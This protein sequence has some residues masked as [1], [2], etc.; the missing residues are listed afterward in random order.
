MR[1][2]ACRLR[3]LRSSRMAAVDG[4]AVGRRPR[5]LRADGGP[6]GSRCAGSGL[7]RDVLAPAGGWRARTAANNGSDR[8]HSTTAYLPRTSVS[9]AARRDH[10]YHEPEE[11]SDDDD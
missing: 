4:V 8:P 5:T 1:I 6:D 9:G 10:R 3:S 2:T 7:M 11:T